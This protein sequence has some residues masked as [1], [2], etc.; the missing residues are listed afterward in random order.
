[1]LSIRL[2]R[3]GKKKQPM[4]RVVVMEKS[5]DP[6]GRAL[7]YL[8]HYN[9][10]TNPKTIELNAERIKHWL[11]QGAQATDTVWNILLKEKI[12]EG[13]KRNVV[14]KSK[15]H[16]PVEA[17]PEAPA[18]EQKTEDEEAPKAPAAEE[19]KED[20]PIEEK[21]EEE[22]EEASGEKEEKS[23]TGDSAS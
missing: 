7:E 20:A 17:E 18:A 5:R 15:S 11:K 23:S 12:V 14:P 16:K 4:Y 9:P 10:R 1:M 19:K 13:E 8:G 21:K 6:Y 2:S 22:K 3:I